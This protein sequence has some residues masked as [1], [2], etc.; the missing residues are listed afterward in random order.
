MEIAQNY[1]T[2]RSNIIKRN[3]LI[4]LRGFFID[5]ISIGIIMY[6]QAKK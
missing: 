4:H 3:P 6:V 2:I 1:L 5:V